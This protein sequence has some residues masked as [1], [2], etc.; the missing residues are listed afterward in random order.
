MTWSLH[1]TLLAAVI[2]AVTASCPGYEWKQ[3][4]DTCYWGRSNNTSLWYEVGEVCN[5]IYPGAE[6]VTIH[7]MELN[8]FIA[9]E[10][11]VTSAG[12]LAYTWIGLSRAS[13]TS[14]WKW[15][16]GSTVNFTQWYMNDD[17]YHAGDCAEIND[18]TWGAWSAW[19]CGS[20]SSYRSYYACQIPAQ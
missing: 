18:Y 16:D 7:D 9:E 13:S 10:I 14:S 6:M 20:D 8:T 3:F 4:R 12:S 19:S 5:L 2:T 15:T 1:L 17:D 11:A